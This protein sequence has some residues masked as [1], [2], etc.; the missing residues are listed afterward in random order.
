MIKSAIAKA[1]KVI[2]SVI[3]NAV[4]GKSGK[5]VKLLAA[6]SYYFKSIQ[7]KKPVMRSVISFN[8]IK[9]VKRYILIGN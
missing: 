9:I 6:P 1:P 3:K 2:E 5:S 8:T 4:I 7:A